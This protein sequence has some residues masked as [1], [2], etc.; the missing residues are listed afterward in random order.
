MASSRIEQRAAYQRYGELMADSTP[1]THLWRY[2]MDKERQSRFDAPKQEGIPRNGFFH[3]GL[4][5]RNNAY[6]LPIYIS[7]EI[8]R[9]TTCW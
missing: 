1:S 7:K 2:A 9:Q 6:T 3:A 4:G 8:S 5:R